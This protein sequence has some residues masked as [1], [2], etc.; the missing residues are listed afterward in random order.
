MTQS[1]KQQTIVASDALTTM[2]E[3]QS[4][5]QQT[6]VALYES[7][8]QARVPSNFKEYKELQDFENQG[9]ESEL[10][11]GTIDVVSIT[12]NLREN[13]ST[14]CFRFSPGIESSKIHS[15][16]DAYCVNA[17]YSYTAQQWAPT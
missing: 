8:V 1:P 15:Y 17:C 16:M 2:L 10:F 3:Q 9:N 4:P 7:T 5:K 14:S 6:I 13:T 11:I 12:V